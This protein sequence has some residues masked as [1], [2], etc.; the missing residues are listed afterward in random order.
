MDLNNINHL[1][2][3]YWE[4]ETSLQDE[5]TLKQYFN[6]G[7]VASEHRQF[8][9]LFQYFKEEQ[10]VLIS[11]NFEIK[12][13][14]R[15]Q[16]EPEVK[17]RKLNWIRNIRSI[18]AVG[19]ILFAAI[20]AF[21]KYSQPEDIK[22]YTLRDNVYIFDDNAEDTDEALAATKLALQ[23]LSGKMKKGSKKATKGLIEVKQA[24]NRTFK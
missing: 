23:L 15:L 17:V 4:G 21:Q 6:N 12:L 9:P 1:L 13:L 19:I 22:D 16:N 20:F 7:Q 8:Q 24:K 10:D 11:D 18:A 14:E 3:K 2:D 5:E